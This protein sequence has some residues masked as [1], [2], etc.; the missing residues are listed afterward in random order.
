MFRSKMTVSMR[1]AS[2]WQGE[3]L[4][5]FSN[6]MP[7][8]WLAVVCLGAVLGVVDAAPHPHAVELHNLQVFQKLKNQKVRMRRPRRRSRETCSMC[9]LPAGRRFVP[10]TTMTTHPRLL[11]ILPHPADSR[12]TRTRTRTT[13]TTQLRL[14]WTRRLRVFAWRTRRGSRRAHG[15]IC[16]YMAIVK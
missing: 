2:I 4:L 6:G 3:Q 8:P 12:P 5:P 15:N 11:S 16:V 7:L 14:L 10:T 1:Y 9:Y 13:M